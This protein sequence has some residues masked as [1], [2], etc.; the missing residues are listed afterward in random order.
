MSKSTIYIASFY[1]MPKQR[2][3][4]I[5]K[6]LL[7][8]KRPVF[9]LDMDTWLFARTA[10]IPCFTIEDF[11]GTE[12]MGDCITSAWQTAQIFCADMDEI[13]RVEGMGLGTVL[14]GRMQRLL[15][16]LDMMQKI[17]ESW[18]AQNITPIFFDEKFDELFSDYQVYGPCL[19]ALA[20]FGDVSLPAPFLQLPPPLSGNDAPI[21]QESLSLKGH[22]LVAAEQD[23]LPRYQSII[24]SLT[25]DG[26]Q[27]QAIMFPFDYDWYSTSPGKNRMQIP[28]LRV[29]PPRLATQMEYFGH[30]KEAYPGQS[31]HP[32]LR[33]M[34]QYLNHVFLYYHGVYLPW[35]A[36]YFQL[37]KTFLK[38]NE[39]KAVLTSTI[40]YP[41][42][43]LPGFAA[44]A[45]DIPTFGLQH[46]FSP[47]RCHVKS[48]RIFLTDM[49]YWHNF[50]LKKGLP[51]RLVFQK[52][53]LIDIPGN[54]P[55]SGGG[56]NSASENRSQGD[57]PKILV[58]AEA[59]RVSTEAGLPYSP[60][61]VEKILRELSN[62]PQDIQ[63]TVQFQIKWHPFAGDCGYWKLCCE[64][65]AMQLLD[66]KEPLRFHLKNAWMTIS[67]DYINSGILESLQQGIPTFLF[68]TPAWR[69]YADFVYMKEEGLHSG[70]LESITELNNVEEL[71]NIIRIWAKNSH[72]REQHIKNL[73]PFQNETMVLP[74]QGQ[75]I[76]DIINSEI[77]L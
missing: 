57:L 46:T 76:K 71:W 13:Y 32:L 75:S 22:I 35:L 10:N 53:R 30:F 23:E 37:W 44:Q 24:Q 12:A 67:V 4:Q 1:N 70:F 9:A 34:W 25:D 27:A 73:Q 42:S 54:S 17:G 63:S 11:I 31:R 41:V 47:K 51:S 72:L 20:H 5:K 50:S 16:A 26:E 21:L 18:R 56:D 68:W 49:P 69:A 58:L 29:C 64:G 39:P 45:L 6:L 7:L 19:R 65:G 28:Y 8:R 74:G 40:F 60:S 66:A 33:E 36:R 77:N 62:P 48:Q 14:A 61:H 38:K 43:T 15:A 52:T 59:F 3:E 55:S 2:T